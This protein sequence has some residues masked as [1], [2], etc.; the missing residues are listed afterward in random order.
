MSQKL[1]KAGSSKRPFISKNFISWWISSR[2]SFLGFSPNYH[3]K[4]VAKA[5]SRGRLHVPRL[6]PG[7]IQ[8]A[9]SI[10]KCWPSIPPRHIANPRIYPWEATK[11]GCEFECESVGVLAF[12]S[13][14]AFRQPTDLSVGGHP[15]APPHGFSRGKVGQI[16]P[17]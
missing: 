1:R 2:F 8:P 17:D 12:H 3:F 9:F 4:V 15:T 5:Q 10:R 14:K 6:K 7:A 11:K 16:R 13:A